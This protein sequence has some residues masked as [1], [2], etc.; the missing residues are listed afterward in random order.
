M[1]RAQRLRQRR[2]I[3]AVYQHGRVFRNNVLTIRILETGM[4]VTRAAFV[5]SGR[6][7]NAVVRNKT[8]RRMR[9]AVR[10][11]SPEPGRDIILSAR[12]QAVHLDYH[13][14]RSSIAQ[15]LVKAGLLKEPAS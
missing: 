3:A 4:P 13:Q 2:D 15:L 1:R 9:E 6:L 10:S 12:N 8:R 5:V 7:G 14:L 11:L